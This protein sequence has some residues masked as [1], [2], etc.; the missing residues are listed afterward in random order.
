MVVEPFKPTSLEVNALSIVQ[1]N[2]RISVAPHL[3]FPSGQEIQA[4][5][6]QV[7]LAAGDPSLV[8]SING[9]EIQFNEA[10]ARRENLCFRAWLPSANLST[11]FIITLTR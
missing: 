5:G 11:F 4:D 8:R 6:V 3:K 7:E 1:S 2:R 10:Q 9:L